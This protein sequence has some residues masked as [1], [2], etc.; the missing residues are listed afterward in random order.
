MKICMDRGAWAEA[1]DWGKAALETGRGTY[2]SERGVTYRFPDF[3]QVFPLQMCA[4][5]AARLGRFEEALDDIDQ[6]VALQESLGERWA[7]PLAVVQKDAARIRKEAHQD[8]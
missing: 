2:Q 7:Q 1:L 8:P 3:M 5:A 4:R 6:A